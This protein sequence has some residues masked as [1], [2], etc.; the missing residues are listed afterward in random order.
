MCGDPAANMLH[1]GAIVCFSCRAFFRRAVLE[2]RTYTCVRGTFGCA[3]DAVTRT[4][5][6]RCRL[7]KCLRVGLNPRLV[8]A[9]KSKVTYFESWDAT[10][11]NEASLESVEKL[12]Q[13]IDKS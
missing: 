7:A 5:C 10:R 13:N 8:D 6:K 9:N 4:N 1:Y 11:R 12:Q 2:R 3:V